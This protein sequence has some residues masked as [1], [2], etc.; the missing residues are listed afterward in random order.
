MKLSRPF[1][2]LSA[3]AARAVLA[4]VLLIGAA[5]QLAPCQ[6]PRNLVI[7]VA[8]D[9]GVD[10]VRAYKEG[11]NPPP[12]PNIDA[13]AGRGVLFRNAWANPS[14]SPTRACILTGRFPFRTYVGRWIRHPNNSGPPSALSGSTSG[15]ARRPRPRERRLRPR[16][17][18]QVAPRDASFHR[19]CAARVRRLRPLRGF[20]RGA[21]P[22]LPPVDARR[23]RPV[24]GH[25]E[26]LHDPE[27]RRCAGVDAEAE[28]CVAALPDLSGAAHPVSRA[29]EQ[30]P[31]PE[32]HGTHSPAEHAH[33]CQSTLLPGDGRVP[34]HGDRPVLQGTRRYDDGEHERSSAATNGSVQKQ[35]VAP[36]D[37][38]RAKGSPYEGGINVPLIVAGPDVVSGG[39]EVQA[40]TCAVDVFATALELCGAKSALPAHVVHDSV[41]LV[42]Y[43]KSPTQAPLRKFAF[44][45]EF[46]GNVWPKPN[47]NGHAMIRNDRYKLIRRM[48]G[49]DEFYDL[50]SDPWERSNLLN[51]TLST[52]QAQNHAALLNEVG[53]LRSPSAA[54]VVYGPG[55]CMG[56]KGVP[57]IGAKG[58]PVLNKT[59]SIELANAATSA[60]TVAADGKITAGE[61][62]LLRA[63]ADTLACPMPPLLSD[64]GLIT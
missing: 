52:V 54:F 11:T 35:A 1:H 48:T 17:R 43:L 37:P 4:G 24:G 42:P 45:E 63:V 56:S 34:R 15:P 25:D 21:D 5:A 46:T 33:G 23:E 64:D 38:N 12:T 20:A 60:A 13:L 40:L 8:D 49:A 41:S 57:T 7:I 59:Y 36:F 19:G 6:T 58:L 2:L 14:C 26:V 62:E 50:Q 39:R 29:A 53:R 16:V 61:A 10:Y 55:S 3:S 28:G 30:P 27:H 47:Q 51:G 9:L 22:R 44:S 31:H 32:P 18:R